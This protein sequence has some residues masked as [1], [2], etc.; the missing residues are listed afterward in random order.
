MIDLHSYF[1]RP[2]TS[3]DEAFLWEMLYL[4][5]FIPP[6]CEPL[7]KAIV[8]EPAL[9]KYVADWGKA[10]DLGF[11]AVHAESQQPIGAAWS[12]LLTGENKGYGYVDDET[13]ELSIAIVPA[14]RDKSVGTTLLKHL[15][16]AARFRFPA[17]CLSVST[18]N[19]ARSLYERLGFEVVALSENSLTMKMPFNG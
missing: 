19:P 12:R 2:A 13:P 18:E 7:P 9:S 10:D 3:N 1:V 4:A 16:E 15:I 17:L 8:K 5:I 6:G 14:W 11:I